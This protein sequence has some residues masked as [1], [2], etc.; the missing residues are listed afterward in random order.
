MNCFL[1]LSTVSTLEAQTLS[2]FLN[3]YLRKLQLFVEFP[4]SYPSSMQGLTFVLGHKSSALGQIPITL[5]GPQ[6][7]QLTLGQTVETVC[8]LT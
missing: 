1:P 8:A 2:P 6:L 5:I 4:F 3:T 7:L